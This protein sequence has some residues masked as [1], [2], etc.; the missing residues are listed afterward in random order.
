MRMDGGVL[1]RKSGGKPPHSIKERPKTQV[2][3]RNLGHPAE[4]RRTA[5]RMGK[6]SGLK[7]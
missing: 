1:V 4:G 7:A 5:M 2:E 3:N 6:A